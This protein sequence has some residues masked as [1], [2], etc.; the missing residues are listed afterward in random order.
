[1]VVEPWGR[2][3]G[4]RAVRPALPPISWGEDWDE[5]RDGFGCAD[6]GRIGPDH[7]VLALPPETRPRGYLGWLHRVMTELAERRGWSDEPLDFAREYCLEAQRRAHFESVPR[8]SPDRRH[9]AVLSLHIDH[10][11][12][13][14]LTLEV[15]DK[16]GEVVASTIEQ[17]RPLFFDFYDW[18]ALRTR[19]R[20]LANDL[21]V[22][23]DTHDTRAV[24]TLRMQ[25]AVP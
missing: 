23:N 14:T 11:G 25:T 5:P 7:A 12:F 18:R 22:V 10:E 9:K 1:M 8:S 17:R 19:V 3:C 16:R 21:V 2:P 13:R 4:R 24:P 20:W 6:G 15:R